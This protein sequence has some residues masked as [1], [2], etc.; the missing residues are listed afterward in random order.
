MS[1]KKKVVTWMMVEF[2]RVGEDRMASKAAATFPEVFRAIAVAASAGIRLAALQKASRWWKQ[3][4]SL[5]EQFEKMP[6]TI[7]RVKRLVG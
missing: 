4:T 2:E 1:E 6:P 5:M 7:S 3:R